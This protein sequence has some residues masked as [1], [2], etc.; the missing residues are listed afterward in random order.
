MA[1]NPVQFQNG[2][3]SREFLFLYETAD[4]CFDAL[5]QRH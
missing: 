5:A 3:S 1:Y 2:I 4:Q